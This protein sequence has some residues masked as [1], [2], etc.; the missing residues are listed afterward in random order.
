MP[1]FKKNPKLDR[2]IMAG[3]HA[4]TDAAAVVL[5]AAVKEKLGESGSSN[6]GAGGI[7]A[8]AGKPPRVASGTLR[9]SIQI[10]RRAIRGPKPLA[11]VGTNVIYA[12][13]LEYGG[14]ITAKRAKMLF[15]PFSVVAR[16][17]LDKVGGKI[18]ELDLNALRG[19]F[20]F[21]RSVR[22]R[23]HPYFRPVLN[24]PNVRKRMTKQAA[25]AFFIPLKNLGKVA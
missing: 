17:A 6:K 5:Q 10:D 8:P 11:R 12:R 1:E 9:R 18:R 7:P 22:I 24:D 4:A 25:I 14:I 15:I 2:L 13:I 16:R 20:A 3:L 19:H 23:P 21:K